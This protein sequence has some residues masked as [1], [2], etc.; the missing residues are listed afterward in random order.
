MRP[1]FG[2]TQRL[3]EVYV[4]DFSGDLYGQHF[5]VEFVQ[6]VRNQETFADIDA[7]IARIEQD[8]AESREVL[9]TARST[10]PLPGEGQ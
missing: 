6:K 4:M 10:V 3:V 2:L 8:V 7:L 5:N 9:S 1:T